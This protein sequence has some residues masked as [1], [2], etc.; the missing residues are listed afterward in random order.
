MKKLLI[1]FAVIVG[2]VMISCAP[3][4][5]GTKPAPTGYTGPTITIQVKTLAGAADL[6]EPNNAATNAV[7]IVGSLAGLKLVSDASKVLQAWTPNDPNALMTYKG[8]GLYEIVLRNDLTN[9]T[10]I[11]FKFANGTLGY[12]GDSG[13]ATVEK[14]TSGGEVNNRSLDVVVG[15]NALATN[16]G[17][18]A[19]SGNNVDVA[20]NGIQNWGGIAPTY[21]VSNV[22]VTIIC[23]NPID[24]PD[25][26]VDTNYAFVGGAGS[27][28]VSGTNTW[29]NI[30][31]LG[32]Q[33]LVTVTGTNISLTWTHTGGAAIA[34]KL[35]AKSA[36]SFSWGDGANV[37][38]TIGIPAAATSVSKTYTN[39]FVTW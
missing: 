12:G 29:G 28:S 9:N 4:G 36:G 17:T 24:A 39:G 21:S 27:L 11:Q 25:G 5:D 2:L 19:V 6:Y 14:T 13:W 38:T 23:L 33:R 15:A 37:Q 18:N 10:T 20:P 3:A 34:V 26:H 16:L 30:T 1:A 22:T 7:Y 35:Q 8:A 31:G 32:D